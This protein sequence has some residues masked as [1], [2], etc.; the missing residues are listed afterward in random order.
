LSLQ[1][2]T[3][4]ATGLAMT[5]CAA[6]GDAV[7]P[8]VHVHLLQGAAAPPPAGVPPADSALLQTGFDAVRRM[9]VP[10]T[11]QDQ[12]PF[13][14]VVDTGAN[15]SV[16]AVDT[17][18]ALSL[19]SAGRAAVHGIAG[20]DPAETVRVRHL[21]VGGFTA[22]RVRMPVL[23]RHHLG[24]DGL[25]GVDILAGRHMIMDFGTNRFSISPSS[26]TFRRE[27]RPRGSGRLSTETQDPQVV[28]VPARYRFGQ[29]T[30]IDAEV[31]AGIPIT[32]FLD[33][34]AQS[35]VGNLALRRAVYT[36]EPGL[37]LRAQQVQL[38]SATGQMVSGELAPIPGLRL[39][40]LRIGNLSCV[41]ADLHTFAIWDLI[42]T[43]AIL[44]GMDVMRHFRAIEL[45]YARREVV[46]RTPPAVAQ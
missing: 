41:F 20:V 4:L 21:R 5:G 6:I 18:Q 26:E 32:A 38:V 30:I 34:G 3:F 37:A 12:G 29:L 13:T 25:L 36:R 23:P 16:I 45:D 1:R 31:G 39:G 2:R 35:T 9:T 46:F 7:A 22:R 15:H 14:F 17:A 43:P 40:G 44:I 28:V 10:V 19:A 11:I 8:P 42:D 27:I 33:S 24:A